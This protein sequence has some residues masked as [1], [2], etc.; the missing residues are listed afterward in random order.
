MC[1]DDLKYITYVKFSRVMIYA[2]NINFLYVFVI[3]LDT[4]IL[5]QF[6]HIKLPGFSIFMNKVNIF[7]LTKIIQQNQIARTFHIYE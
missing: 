3:L 1:K 4:Y 7:R 6:N 5:K 2:I